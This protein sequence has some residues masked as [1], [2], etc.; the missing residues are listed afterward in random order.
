MVYPG[1]LQFLG[2]LFEYFLVRR[3]EG[4]KGKGKIAHA[5]VERLNRYLQP[6]KTFPV[7]EVLIKQ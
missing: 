2:N 1:A 4:K 7:N 5:D 3:N 6:N